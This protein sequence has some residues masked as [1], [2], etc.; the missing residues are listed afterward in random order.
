MKKAKKALQ[1]IKNIYPEAETELK[2]WKTPFQLLICILL[3]AQTTDKQVNKVTKKLFKKYSTP[4]DLANSKPK[5]IEKEISS[6][7]YYRNKAK[8]IYQTSK[9]LSQKEIPK[10]ISELTKLPGIGYKTAAVFL[11]E[12]YQMNAGIAVDTHV[13]RVTN[14]IGIIKNEKNPTKIAKKLEKIYSKKNWND[15]NSTFVLFG[16]YICKA[17][18]PKCPECPLKKICDYYQKQ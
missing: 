7:N 14:R 3:S 4:Q 6:I 9:I 8:Y 5:Q 13:K 12:Y 18:K 10:N 11:N 16:R 15:I 2:N 17:R 1:E